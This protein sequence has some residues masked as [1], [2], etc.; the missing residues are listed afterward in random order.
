MSAPAAKARWQG[1]SQNALTGLAQV[2]SAAGLKLNSSD[3]SGSS[4]SGS[5]SGG[6]GSGSGSGG[7]GSSGGPGGLPA[8]PN[9]VGQAIAGVLK[10]S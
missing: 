7:S 6:S 1:V 8:V 3:M 10:T 2:A 9:S 5:G 4:G